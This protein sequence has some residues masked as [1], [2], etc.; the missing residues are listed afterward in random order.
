MKGDITLT[1]LKLIQAGDMITKDILNTISYFGYTETYRRM[2][3]MKS[4]IPERKQI[5]QKTIKNLEER[6]RISKLLCKL[7]TAGLIIK[8]K[9]KTGATFWKITE[10][11]KSEMIK[12]KYNSKPNYK[13]ERSNEIKI[14]AF[15]IPETKKMG[16]NWL[17]EALKN[18]KFRMLQKSVWI[19]KT[20]LPEE[21]F[22]DLQRWNILPYI[23]IFAISKTGTI[24]QLR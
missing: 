6:Q 19:G 21:F 7:K 12:K 15:D 5:L 11:G 3:G 2:K 16:R 17:R 24:K 20:I 10:R 22:N 14:V 13:I 9:N 1:I 18:L 4:L 23:E 8:E